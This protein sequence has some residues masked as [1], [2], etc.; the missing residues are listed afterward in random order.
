MWIFCR[1]GFFSAVEA[2]ESQPELGGPTEVLSIRARFASDLDSLREVYA[3]T[4]G[5]TVRLPGRDY[6]YRAYITK[7][8]FAG[9]MV[10]V[11]LDLDYSS[12]KAMVA[13]EQGRLR[14]HLYSDVWSVMNDAENKI[15][16][17]HRLVKLAKAR[18]SSRTR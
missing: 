12:F 1:A 16:A 8:A 10:K 15:A 11:A 3:P 13:E 9:V 2:A 7:E 6:P 4:L 5:P 18:P 17:E 14:A